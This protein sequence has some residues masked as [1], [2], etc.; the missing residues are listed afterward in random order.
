M[1]KVDCVM[2]ACRES[3][4]QGKKDSS[5]EIATNCLKNS[6]LSLEVISVC[7]GLPLEKVMELKS[8]L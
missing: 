8:N 4:E 3:Y 5:I 1:G 2:E 7:T 6:N